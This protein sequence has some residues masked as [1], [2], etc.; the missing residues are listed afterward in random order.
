MDSSLGAAARALSQ[1]DP[2]HALKHVALRDDAPALALRGIAMAQ[3]GE[4]S[5]AH[6]LLRRAEKAFAL[7]ESVARARCLLARAEVALARRDLNEAGRGLG[8]A[9]ELLAARGDHENALLAALLEVRRSTLLG[10]V[11][12]AQAAL[13]SLSFDR[14]PARLLTL[15]ALASADLAMKR[16]D[17]V[18]ARTALDAAGKAANESRIPQLL[19]EVERLAT[20]LRSPAARLVRAGRES[21]LFIHELLPY[22]NPRELVV[23]ACRREVR[24]RQQAVSLVRRPVLLELAVALTERASHEATR[25]ELVE[26]VFGVRRI[27]DSHRVRLRVEVGRLR[28]VLLG[29]AEVRA[30]KLGYLLAPVASPEV[31]LLL[32]PTDGPAS[33]LLALLHG[34]E[35]WATSSLADALG[36]SQ[37]AV[38][39]ALG[40]LEREGVVQAVGKGR[41]RRWVTAVAPTSSVALL[42]VPPGTL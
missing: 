30:T 10:S 2:L 39:R 4:L 28:H 32:P 26:R 14:A 6:A 19:A 35:T 24:W 17:G 8:A 18:A 15:A 36:K 31:S 23:D 29:L 37:R 34:G 25:A 27:N 41:A 33:A 16:L 38:Q 13:S 5:S 3:L 9:R 20:R 1:G 22:R 40:D 42:L 7:G 12:A 21:A 11:E